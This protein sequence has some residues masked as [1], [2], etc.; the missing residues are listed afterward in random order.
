LNQYRINQ[1]Q[2]GSRRD[3]LILEAIQER[4]VLD[5]D[6][7]RAIFFRM[8]YGQRKAQERLQKLFAAGKVNR[9]ESVKPFVYYDGERPAQLAHRLGVNWA[10]IWIEQ[11][12]SSWEKL[13]SFSYEQDHGQLRADGFVA[14]KNTVSGSIRFLFLELDRGT[15]VFDKV[16]KYC[17]LYESGKYASWWWVEL[18]ERFPPVLIVTTSPARKERIL[19]LIKKENSSG[20]EFRVRLL[21]EIKKEVL[22]GSDLGWRQRS[23]N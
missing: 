4:Q 17:R 6:Q 5:A 21:E 23:V 16:G 8:E 12:C 20:L 18:T 22:Y 3:K 15:N 10:R 1:R 13:H 11:S 14:V 9:D 19:E 2:K 7:V